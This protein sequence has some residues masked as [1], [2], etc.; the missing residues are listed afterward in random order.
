VLR[1]VIL[2][3]MGH[4]LGLEH[5]RL[6]IMRPHLPVCYFIDPGDARDAF[7]PTSSENSFQRFEC[8]EGV[9]DPMLS[10]AQRAKLDAFRGG[11]LG[12]SLVNPG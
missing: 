3:E 11:E 12:W 5:H 7:D 1:S 4:T 8:L 10:P 9:Q 6:G 2:H